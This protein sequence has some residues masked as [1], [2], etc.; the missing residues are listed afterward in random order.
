[1]SASDAHFHASDAHDETHGIPT[2]WRRYLFST[3]HKD[4][5]TLYLIFAIIAGVIGGLMSMAIRAELMYPGIQIFPGLAHLLQ[6]ADPAMGLDAGKN[7][8]NVFITA[9]GVI[10]IFFMVMPALIGG[11]GN[12]FVPIMIGAPD[13]AFPRMN[14]ISFWLLPAS[15]TL[16][17]MSL[18]FEGSPGMK[19]FGGGWVLYPPFSSNTGAPGPAMDFIILSLHLAGASSILGAINFITTIFN[20]RAPGMTLHKMPLFAWSVLVTAFLLVLSLPVLAGAIT[21]LLT[22]RNFGTTFFDP[23]GGG[24]PILFQH[25]FWFFGHPEVYILILP[26]FGIISH[27]ISTFSRKPIFG[28]LG[29]AY[30]MVAIGFVG[31]I[32]WAHHMYTVGLSLN[33]QRYFVFATM[34]IAVPTGVKIFSWIATMWGGSISL[35]APMVWAIGFIFLFTVGGVTGVV[36]SNAGVDRALHETYYVVAHFHYTMSLGA[37]FAIFAGF[38]YWFPK[39]SGYMYNEGMAKLH[40]WVMFVGINLTFFPQHFLGLAGMPRRYIDYPDAFHLWNEVS[41]IGSFLSGGS[42]LIFFYC[43]YDAFKRKEAAGDNP[44]GPGATTL[45]WTLSSP[46]PY[47]QFND[48]PHFAET[49]H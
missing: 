48:L 12:W 38:Y 21:M 24:D 9:H 15:F 8:Y 39:M 27:I 23:A 42:L 32:V 45:E 7:L 6:G 31:F 2:G 14:N 35:R 34:V 29:M 25:L 4:I 36:L 44:W 17:F 30:A 28:Y 19:G 18:F 41:S 47:H 43:V 49:N 37:V 3:N 5:G 16:L 1:M 40:F 33:T 13:M 11:F 10:M 46:P 26:G 22:D 20:M